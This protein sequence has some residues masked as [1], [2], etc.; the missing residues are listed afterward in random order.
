MEETVFERRQRE[1]EGALRL[2]ESLVDSKTMLP[3]M[4]KLE[5]ALRALVSVQNWMEG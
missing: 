2:V 4:G 1:L 5:E 3:V